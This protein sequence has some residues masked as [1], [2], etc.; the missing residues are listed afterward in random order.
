M[1]FDGTQPSSWWLNQSATPT[2]VQMVADPAG[3]AGLAQEFTTLNTDVAPLTPTVNPRSQ[4][5]GPT[6]IIKQGGTYWQSFQVY[7]PKTDTL[8][9]DP[10]QWIGLGAVAYGAPF[11]GS[12]PVGISIFN[13]MFRFQRNQNGPDPYQIS[14][15]APVVKGQWY[16]FT[17]HYLF[18]TA[19]WVELY[20]NGVQVNLKY[21]STLVKQLPIGM[22]DSTDN[23]GPWGPQEQLYY[24]LNA[25]PSASIYFKNY[26]IAST[27]ALAES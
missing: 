19:G 5:T 12:P 27:Q 11:N 10:N 18:S 6:G 3:G 13:N 14:W 9:T 24:R 20:V 1:F 15:T 26:K 21:G 23:K 22:I 8:P 2:R 16:R 4:L 7:V 25:M 17:W